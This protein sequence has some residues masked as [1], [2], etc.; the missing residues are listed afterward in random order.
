MN[1]SKAEIILYPVGVLV[2]AQSIGRVEIA[3]LRP[4]LTYRLL[5]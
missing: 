3:C 4:L 5:L 2:K 1:L